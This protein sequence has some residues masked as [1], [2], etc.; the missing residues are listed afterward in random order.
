MARHHEVIG[1]LFEKGVLVHQDFLDK[2][3]G[4]EPPEPLLD[5]LEMEAD[6]LVLNSDYVEILSQPT[7]LVDWY[8]L[9]KFRVEVE[10]DRDD[11]LYQRHLR[12]FQV[13]S[14]QIIPRQEGSEQQEWSSLEVALQIE[15]GKS[16]AAEN[17][18]STKF[19]ENT[20]NIPFPELPSP[21]SNILPEVLGEKL[22]VKPLSYPSTV[23]IIVS[24]QNV[25][26][27]YEVKDF[28][29]FFITRY[30]Y[31]E[32]L[33]RNRQELQNILS[34][35][36][37]GTIREK[38]TLSVIGVVAEISQTKAGNILL[39]LEDL[40]GQ[41]KVII[42]K[43]KAELFNEA[44]DLVVDEVIGI[45]GMVR[46]QMMFADAI[47]WPDL[48]MHLELKKK[49]EGEEE[50]AIF[51]SDIHVG[52]ALFLRE[53]FERFLQWINGKAGNEE[54]REVAR[55]VKYVFMVGDLVDGI[56]VYPAQEPEL[57]IK[58]ITRQYAEFTSL[59]KQIPDT[60]QII[61][62]PGNHDAVHIAEPQPALPS[63]LAGELLQLPNITL[64]TN[65]AIVNI[66]R[67]GTF[68]GF[69]VL[70]YHG[71]SFD[72]YVANVESIRNGGGYQ[73]ADLIMKFLLKRR[74]LA[75]AFKSTPY[76]PGHAE[77][78]LLIR[79]IPDFFVTGH[80]H[81]SSVA[82]YKGVTMISCSCW[83][84]KTT[85]QEKLGHKPEPA[86]LPV[87]NLKTREIKVLRFG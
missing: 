20:E 26:K 28:T 37:L 48:P 5:R 2:G 14:L 76:F 71:Y 46:E 74:H 25:P 86:R 68:P 15:P 84:G 51:L 72:Y 78:P 16:L 17:H 85:F 3:F 66:A 60:K 10:K 44:K 24:Y 53:E 38:E 9:D 30:Q 77:D 31:L 58:D 56:G 1:Q 27:K 45:R 40:T 82:N 19:I 36:R 83:Q 32:K 75:P 7:S 22:L 33:L 49:E 64:V 11:D 50:Y 43:S 13:S 23:N 67:T 47:L 63:E 35:G 41:V 61:M 4:Q 55:K 87:V 54:Q 57:A 6:I 52:S 18:F 29:S 81:Y 42:T 59:V 73:R 39:T 69:E 65:P 12:E 62:C 21:G 70:M 79:R 34:I 80:I 8:E